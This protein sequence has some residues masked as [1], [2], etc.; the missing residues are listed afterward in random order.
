MENSANE[1]PQQEFFE[2]VAH[3]FGYS[4]AVVDGH[5]LFAK[6]GNNIFMIHSSE[7]SSETGI[8]NLNDLLGRFEGTKLYSAY[9]V[10]SV[11]Q[12][13]NAENRRAYRSLFLSNLQ[14]KLR[15]WYRFEVD[16]DMS[17]VK[18]HVARTPI[19]L[20]VKFEDTILSTG[21]AII[22]EEKD[23]TVVNKFE[24]TSDVETFAYIREWLEHF[25]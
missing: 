24:T 19:Y 23:F 11:E 18:I 1:L 16:V 2:E 20:T 17:Y 6:N 21:K 14:K 7:H 12:A 3:R 13:L 9:A 10:S 5:G 8:F 25:S 15:Y 22:T 4:L